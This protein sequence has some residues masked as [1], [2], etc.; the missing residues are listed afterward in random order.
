L[1]TG[2]FGGTFNPIHY[3]HLRAAEEVREMLS[4][5]RVLFIPSG[6]PPL[7]TEDIAEAAHRYKMVGLAVEDNPLFD[8][9]D[10]ECSSPGKSYTVK[11]VETLLGHYAD[12]ALFF[13]LGIDA[14]LDIAN[15]WQPERLVALVNFAIISRPGRKFSDL[16]SSPY[17][18]VREGVLRQLDQ[19]EAENVRV[20][21]TSGKEA[22]LTRVTHMDVS[23]TGIRGRLQ[24]GGSVKY[25]LPESVRSFIISHKLYNRGT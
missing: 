23:S 19:G 3:G 15:W 11:T 5:E 9:L 21:L 25:L 17:L 22:V 4:L 16:S 12:S 18:K 10:I 20:S 8:V 13:I 1:R 24:G 14:F 7:K 2:V 6:N